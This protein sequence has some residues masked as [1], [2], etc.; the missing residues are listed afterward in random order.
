MSPGG[1]A[2]MLGAAITEPV[3]DKADV[4]VLFIDAGGCLD[5]CGHGTI[6][7]VTSLIETGLIKPQHPCTKVGIDTPAG[8]VSAVGKMKG[9]KV[10]EVTIKNVASFLFKKGVTVNLDGKGPVTV[11]I[12][13]GGNFFVLV[14]AKQLGLT[15]EPKNIGAL[16]KI[17]LELRDKVNKT[18]EVRHPVLDISNVGLVEIYQKVTDNHFKNIVIFGD[19]QVDRSPC[20]TGTS[21]KIA[22]LYAKGEI[23]KGQVLVNESVIGSV[24]KGK[25]VDVAKV[26]G[27]DA[28]VPEIT[29]SAWIT[30]FNHQ[31]IDAEDPFKHGFTIGR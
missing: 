4:G 26:G 30:G 28:I 16:T 22:D 17:G 15:V 23:G 3:S 8:L 24:F 19:G 21:A 6:G 11:D 1:H 27:Y 29:G 25:I 20:G 9:N 10:E 7:V 2:D 12:A 5:M 13:Y 14:D 18:V 31:V